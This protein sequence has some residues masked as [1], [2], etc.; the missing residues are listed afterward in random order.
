MSF[1]DRSQ[2]YIFSLRTLLTTIVRLWDSRNHSTFKS[3]CTTVRWVKVDFTITGFQVASKCARCIIN[4]IKWVCLLCTLNLCKQSTLTHAPGREKSCY[5][6][7]SSSQMQ[8]SICQSGEGRTMRKASYKLIPMAQVVFNHS[9]SGH[10]ET[11]INTASRTKTTCSFLLPVNKINGLAQRGPD[12]EEKKHKRGF[13]PDLE[14]IH[15]NQ[16]P[17]CI[18]ECSTKSGHFHKEFK[19]LKYAIQPKV[20]RHPWN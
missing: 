19:D 6:K 3:K 17:I 11:N 18:N 1:K 9:S 15:G 4:F 13:G 5:A 12:T 14:W 20:S 7:S 2:A 8:F 10:I 16:Y